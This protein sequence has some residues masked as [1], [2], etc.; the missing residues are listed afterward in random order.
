MR[1]QGRVN[2]RRV[3]KIQSHNCLRKETVPFSEWEL[4]MD[5]AKDRDK[6][7]FECPNGAFSSVDSMFFWRN[8]LKL[9]VILGKGIFQIL[10]AFVVQD[11]QI[12][13][14][15]LTSEQQV[16]LFPGIANASSFAIWD[17]NR[18][19]GICVLLVQDKEIVVAA[20][21]RDMEATRLVRV[22]LEKCLMI[23]EG[24]ANM[25]GAGLKRWG[26]VI[27]GVGYGLGSQG[28]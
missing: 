26:N 1:R 3:K 6:V 21:G 11:V 13:R 17:G 2:T 16:R 19:D 27:I 14:M 4:G 15:T 12:G 28:K 10:G 25:V 24:N 20:T 8:T 22:R 9:D 18:V 5:G 7:I 23:K